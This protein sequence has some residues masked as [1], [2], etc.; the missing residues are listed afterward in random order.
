MQKIVWTQFAEKHGIPGK[1]RDQVAKE[2]ATKNDFDTQQLSA[3]SYK[4]GARSK[5]YI[6]ILFFLVQ[7]FLYQCLQRKRL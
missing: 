4:S 3:R 1:N 6:Y 2:F 5:K 7:T